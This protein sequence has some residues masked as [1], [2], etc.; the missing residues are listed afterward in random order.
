MAIRQRLKTGVRVA[1]LGSLFVTFMALRHVLPIATLAR[2]AWNAPAGPRQR[3]ITSERIVAARVRRI[4]RLAG[5]P[6]GQCLARGL[7]LYRELSRMGANPQLVIGFKRELEMPVGHAWV[8]VDGRPIDE[9]PELIEA[10]APTCAYG[11]RG[12]LA[13]TLPESPTAVDGLDD[14]EASRQP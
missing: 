12:V 10:L 3:N 6:D 13:R 1:R 8:V 7:V 4:M 5:D 9:P 11:Q 2:W 14:V